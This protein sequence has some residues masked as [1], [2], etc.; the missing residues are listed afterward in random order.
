MDIPPVFIARMQQNVRGWLMKM[1]QYFRLMH[2]PADTGIEVVA[3]CLKE[4]AEAKFNGESW[5][6]ETG[7]RRYW[8][9]LAEFC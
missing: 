7:A 5:Q 1:E 6:I 8:R 9:S 2:Y 3:K 4:V